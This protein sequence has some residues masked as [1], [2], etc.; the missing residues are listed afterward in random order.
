[1]KSRFLVRPVR[2]N[3]RADWQTL[4]EG[5]NAFYGREGDTAL[6]PAVLA[7]T[8]GRLLEAS[9]PVHGLVAEADGRLVGL[10]HIIFH[11]NTIHIEDT[12]YLQDLFTAEECRGRGVARQL[13][14]AVYETCRVQGMTSVYWHT[15]ASNTAAR[16]LYDKLA[17][18]TDFLVYRAKA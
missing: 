8:W 1:M 11:R 7:A 6:S 2:E 9:E 16:V 3:D 14:E 17:T 18:N 5:Y 4:W 12:C 10:A 13:V 15:H